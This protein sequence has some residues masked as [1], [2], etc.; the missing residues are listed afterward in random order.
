MRSNKLHNKLISGEEKA[1]LA[2]KG[3]ANQRH[4]RQ[5]RDQGIFCGILDKGYRNQPLSAKQKRRNRGPLSIRNA[6]ERPFA[7][8]KMVLGHDRC[9]YYD[10]GVTGV[11]S[12]C[13]G[14]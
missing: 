12:F 8:M 3:Y 14:P 4:K 7:F 6:A 2:D 9:S 10:Q 1:I 5:L 11:R 13:A